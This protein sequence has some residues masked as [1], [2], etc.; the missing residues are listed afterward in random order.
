MRLRGW[1][2]SR[3]PPCFSIPGCA[4]RC[5]ALRRALASGPPLPPELGPVLRPHSG[6]P[7]MG[8]KG[9]GNKRRRRPFDRVPRRQLAGL[10]APT[11][12]GR[13]MPGT[14]ARRRSRLESLPAPRSAP[15][16]LGLSR[17][18]RA[19]I[20]VSRATKHLSG[21]AARPSHKSR[22]PPRQAS[23]LP[24]LHRRR[25]AEGIALTP[26]PRYSRRR[27][28]AP[29]PPAAPTTTGRSS[30]RR[31]GRQRA[32]NGRQARRT[33]LLNLQTCK[34]CRSTSGR[35]SRRLPKRREAGQR[36]GWEPCR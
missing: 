8:G 20:A 30:R 19:L 14:P 1:S 15:R 12:T 5:R 22:P 4:R 2:E 9:E 32:P 33:C 11:A 25:A 3:C 6:I 27:G 24:K 29:S 28:R 17:V 18:C 34:R 7:A 31:G 23:P 36:S 10:E 35:G 21:K 26:F 13:G 16:L